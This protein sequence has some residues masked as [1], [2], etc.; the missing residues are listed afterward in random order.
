VRVEIGRATRT[1]HFVLGVRAVGQA[2]AYKAWTD[3]EC[4]A[5]EASSPTRHVMTE[6]MLARYA[7]QR[8]GD[9]LKM[10]HSAYNAGLVVAK[11]SKTDTQMTTSNSLFSRT[12]ALGRIS[13]IGGLLLFFGQLLDAAFRRGMIVGGRSGHTCTRFSYNLPVRFGLPSS[14]CLVA[15]GCYAIRRK[16]GTSRPGAPLKHFSASRI[17]FA[18]TR[19]LGSRSTGKANPSVCPQYARV[20]TGTALRALFLSRDRP[21]NPSSVSPT[22]AN[23]C[24]IFGHWSSGDPRPSVAMRIAIENR[25]IGMLS[26]LSGF[27]IASRSLNDPTSPRKQGRKDGDT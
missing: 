7:G 5:F 20:G 22:L 3:A 16:D 17:A 23:V 9:V 26:I 4:A 15:R 6:Y 13:P 19:E 11:P 10:T 14:A 18:A 12:H 25:L 1:S 24:V 27:Y 8:R 21:R 2:R